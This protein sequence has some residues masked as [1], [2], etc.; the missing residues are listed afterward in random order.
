LPTSPTWSDYLVGSALAEAQRSGEQVHVVWPL[1]TQ[2]S[3]QVILESSS[4]GMDIDE[5]QRAR[6]VE[7]ITDWLAVE[8]LL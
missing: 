2:D 8:A 4:N 7:G 6:P 1:S 3:A 5:E